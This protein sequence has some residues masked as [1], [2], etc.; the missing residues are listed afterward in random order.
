MELEISDTWKEAEKLKDDIISNW[1]ILKDYNDEFEELAGQE[2]LIFQKKLHLLDEFVSKWNGLLEPYTTITLF[3]KQDLEKYSE[4]TTALK[5]LRG[6]DFT[7]NHWREVF[8]LIEIEYVKPET[9]LMKDLL[10]VAQNI[11]KHMKE[12]QKISATASSE[13]SVRSALNELELWFAGARLALDARHA[14]QRRVCVVTNY[15]EMIAK[16]EEQQW[17]VS[18]AGAAGGA[19]E[20]RLEAAR[21]FVRAAHHAQRRSVLRSQVY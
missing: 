5:Y 17:V 20:A 10:N 14:A 8:N 12:L 7:E 21:R 15:K 18:A 9:L 6:T 11:K 1:T 2:W 16:V 3:I 19:W 13:A 4:L